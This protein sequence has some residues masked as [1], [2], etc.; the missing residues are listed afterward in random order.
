MHVLKLSVVHEAFAPRTEYVIMG[1][2]D[3]SD[4]AHLE[5]FVS[6][7]EGCDLVVAA[8]FGAGAQCLLL[9][10]YLGNWC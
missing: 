10:Q 3:G 9:H 1:D 7:F 8:G 5:P 6:G 2:A 4:F